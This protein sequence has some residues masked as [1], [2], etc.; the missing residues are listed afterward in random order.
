[1]ESILTRA[2]QDKLIK[3]ASQKYASTPLSEEVRKAFYEVPRHKFVS[4]YRKWPENDWIKISED[5]LEE[6][7]PIIYGDH[8]L[9]IF[10]E[11][12][13]FEK[14]AGTQFLSTISQPSFVLR[15]M[16]ILRPEKGH[17]V[18]ELGTGSG[19]N[20][21]LLGKIVGPKGK[22][23][24]ME[25]IPELIKRAKAS[26][27]S[28]NLDNVS[29]YSGDAGDGLKDQAPFDRVVFTA[30]SYDL[31]APF[32]NQIRVGGLL[33]F[34]LKN[35]GGGDN[36]ILLEKKS[37]H[38]QSIYSM[39]CVFV[40]VTGK[41]H[42]K[43]MEEKCLEDLIEKYELKIAGKYWWK[44]EERFF[45]NS[46]GLKSFLAVAYEEFIPV[47]LDTNKKTFAFWDKEK[48]SLAVAY[49]DRIESYGSNM[50]Q[51]KLIDSI[52]SWIDLGM[53]SCTTMNLKVYPIEANIPEYDWIIKRNESQFLWS[54]R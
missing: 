12:K 40:P 33:L 28:L 39:A 49:H 3:T 22:V 46:F 1:M 36:V 20:A 47:L 48:S 25:I 7:L 10:G 52:R 35:Q 13:D 32:F 15:L 6:N 31:P 8:P 24:S 43:D 34:V 51:I 27:N 9:V 54:I 17:K 19:W 11:N 45:W 4:P 2:F 30:G 50:A 26:I 42:V 18:F 53:P 14:P 41:Y 23:F 37:D 44:S 5:N 38:F 16:D 21:A 29:I